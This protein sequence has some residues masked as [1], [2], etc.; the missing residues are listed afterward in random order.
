M[1]LV[2]GTV[3]VGVAM[4]TASPATAHAPPGQG[5]VRQSIT[6]T[7]GQTFAI[8]ETRGGGATVFVDGQ[9][10]VLLSVSFSGPQG[11][12]TKTFGEKAG[13]TTTTL[14]CTFVEDGVT[15]SAAVVVVPPQG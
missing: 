2:L 9:H 3:A 10:T 11:T 8:V 13:L 12:F 6:C 7:S 5:L 15:I 4:L 14:T 1:R